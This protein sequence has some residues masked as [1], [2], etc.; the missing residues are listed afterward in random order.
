VTTHVPLLASLFSGTHQ[1]SIFP[2]LSFR[3]KKNRQVQK[4]ALSIRCLLLKPRGFACLRA[5]FFFFF[6]APSSESHPSFSLPF[7][8]LF[9]FV[10]PPNEVLSVKYSKVLLRVPRCSTF[11]VHPRLRN[12][13]IYTKPN[14]TREV[15]FTSTQTHTEKRH[16]EKNRKETR[17]DDA[18]HGKPLLSHSLFIKSG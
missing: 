13:C 1:K 2:S 7:V 6:I 3:K 16:L 4:V 14:K 11:S 12:I 9:L 5:R 15:M 17:K 18:P 8:P 10:S